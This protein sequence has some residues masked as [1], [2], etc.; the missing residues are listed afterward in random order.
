MFGNRL[1]TL[2]C[3]YTNYYY[4]TWANWLG[5]EFLQFE[6]LGLPGLGNRGIFNRL[7]ELIYKRKLNADDH[8]VIAWSTPMREDRYYSDK[9][10]WMGVGNIYNQRFYSDSWV[11]E[12]FDPFMSL[13]ETI[14]YIHAG[15]HMLDHIGCKYAFTFMMNPY[16]IDPSMEKNN[17]T[18][19]VDLCDPDNKLKPYLNF[20]L[21]NN[22]II[23]TDIH[24]YCKQYEVLNNLPKIMK[25]PK[26]IDLHPNPMAMYFY[27]KDILCPHM[28]YNGFDAS[29][30]LQSLSKEWSDFV[31]T[32]PRTNEEPRFPRH[33]KTMFDIL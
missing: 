19:F 29:N 14:N 12:F 33:G 15:L 22:K 28:G 17:S 32:I 10:G 6:N 26:V 2:G 24:N 16:N 3:S 11:K 5:S 1:F 8:I 25:N 31:C 27:T 21:E 7:S 4:P 9:G 13:M 30:K 23:K 18:E 20:I